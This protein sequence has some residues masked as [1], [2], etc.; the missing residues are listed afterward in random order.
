[1]RLSARIRWI[2]Q[3]ENNRQLEPALLDLLGAITQN[4]SLQQAAR[5]NGLSYR[6][7]W[8]LIRK[9]EQIFASPLV[10]FSRGRGKK[11]RLS[12]FGI[13]LL[14]WT[15]EL[16]GQIEP[17]LAAI[18][19]QLN[20]HLA[21]YLDI[22]DRQPVRIR[23]SHDLTLQYLCELLQKNGRFTVDLQTCGSLDALRALNSG[24]CHIAGFHFPVQ[25][26]DDMPGKGFRQLLEGQDYI[27]LKLSTREQGIL[28]RQGNPK[29]IRTLKDL[30][31]RSVRFINRQ[32]YS[33]TRSIFDHLLARE[34]IRKEKIK[35]YANEEFTHIAVA[36]LISSGAADA[37]FGIQAVTRQFKLDFIPC[38]Q[39]I[40]VL[41]ISR[42]IPP[43][44]PD[45]LKK[46]LESEGFRVQSGHLPGIDTGCAGE[47]LALPLEIPA[48]KV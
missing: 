24:L 4:G 23:A 25:A 10:M 27:L 29:K 3:D 19:D 31:R 45:L 21:A 48:V 43:D 1:M 34:G 42:K 39:E 8:G 7:A 26:V 2:C 14:Q 6:H 35:G 17:G 32:R 13:Q 44:I 38:L 20:A 36:A 47:E 30:T 18:S 41:A 9:W 22:P 46:L 16:G 15:R 33:G 40:Y 11:T 28:H 12:T 5:V 37:G